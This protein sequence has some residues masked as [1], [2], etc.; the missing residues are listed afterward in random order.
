MHLF[1]KIVYL[2]G[3]ISQCSHIWRGEGWEGKEGWV[4]GL[5]VVIIRKITQNVLELSQ[6]SSKR[7]NLYRNFCFLKMFWNVSEKQQQ[8]FRKNILKKIKFSEAH[9]QSQPRL[10]E[11]SQ[12]IHYYTTI[13]FYNMCAVKIEKN[14]DKFTVNHSI[15]YWSDKSRQF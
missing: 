4:Y 12:P 5:K 13:I 11:F 10:S 8:I 2:L 3:P 1:H 14:C 7:N 6:K 9:A 15:F